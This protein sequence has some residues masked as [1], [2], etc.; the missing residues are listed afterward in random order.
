VADPENWQ[1]DQSGLTI[2]F[3]KYSVAPYCCT[4]HPVTVG[5]D[6]LKPLVRA[7]LVVPK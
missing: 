7:D 6:E 1:L 2:V 3:G 5:W 4:P